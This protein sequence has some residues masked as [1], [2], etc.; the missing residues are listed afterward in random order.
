MVLN[1]IHPVFVIDDWTAMSL[2]LDQAVPVPGRDLSFSL[3]DFRHNTSGVIACLVD[4]Q[5]TWI[6]TKT[7]AS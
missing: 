5:S 4:E 7:P 1:I 2:L 3:S 6:Y